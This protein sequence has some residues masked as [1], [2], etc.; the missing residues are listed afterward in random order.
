MLCQSLVLSPLTGSV[1][2]L[3]DRDG[4]PVS[5]LGP[6]VADRSSL[7]EIAGNAAGIPA[8]EAKPDY[9]LQS[10]RQRG[11]GGAVEE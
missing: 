5:D 10:E 6:A 2:G 3:T 9:R 8:E 4:H 7:G 11:G 1:A